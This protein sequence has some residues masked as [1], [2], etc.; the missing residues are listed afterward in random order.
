[1]KHEKRVS[2]MNKFRYKIKFRKCIFQDNRRIFAHGYSSFT[3]IA[4][5]I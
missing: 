1:M 3:Y 5:E 2:G 4:E